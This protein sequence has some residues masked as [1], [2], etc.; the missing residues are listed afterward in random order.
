MKDIFYIAVGV[1][2]FAV[3]WYVTRACEKL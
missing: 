1:A 2:F 3:C